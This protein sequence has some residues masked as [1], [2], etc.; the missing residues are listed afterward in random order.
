MY[1]CRRIY[2]LT[3]K[4]SLVEENAITVIANTFEQ[5]RLFYTAQN[6]VAH[7]DYA[8]IPVFVTMSLRYENY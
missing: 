7:E 6:L 4:C 8:R 5:F 2:R 3:A 1:I